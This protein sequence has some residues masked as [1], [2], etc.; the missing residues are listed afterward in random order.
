M[1]ARLV[2][3]FLCPS[4]ATLFAQTRTADNGNPQALT[5]SIPY[6]QQIR[7]MTH[8][9]QPQF[10][11]TQERNTVSALANQAPACT[12]VDRKPG[13]VALKSNGGFLSVGK[14]GSVATWCEYPGTADTFQRI[15]TFTGGPVLLALEAH[16]GLRVDFGSGA[17]QADSPGPE[18]N[19]PEGVRFDWILGRRNLNESGGHIPTQGDTR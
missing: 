6:G 1:D 10:G 2:P 7:L 5:R 17:L 15:G 16:N 11:V 3:L 13:R 8:A 14:D 12:A 4:C 9:H 19:G 18:S